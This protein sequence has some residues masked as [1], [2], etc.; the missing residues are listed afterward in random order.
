MKKQS[1][2]KGDPVKPEG[3][4]EER[5]E[6]LSNC[7]DFPFLVQNANPVI[8]DLFEVQIK[9]YLNMGELSECYLNK[10][11]RSVCWYEGLI[12]TGMLLMEIEG[13]EVL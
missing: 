5:W 13:W 1:Q 9:E 10:V 12:D 7:R 8:L 2:K 4:G 3:G 11:P 6:V